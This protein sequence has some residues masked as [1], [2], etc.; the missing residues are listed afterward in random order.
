MQL[1]SVYISMTLE[2]NRMITNSTFTPFII[3]RIFV[4]II[5]NHPPIPQHPPHPLLSTCDHCGSTF[6]LYTMPIMLDTCVDS[7]IITTRAMHACSV[8]RILCTGANFFHTYVYG[9][10][11]SSISIIQREQ[12]HLTYGT[13]RPL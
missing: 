3:E 4:A 9:M 5:W 11:A 1:C 8:N 6:T 12:K 10:N 2:S 13:P 7:T